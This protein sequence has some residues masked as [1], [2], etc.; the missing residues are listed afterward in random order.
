MKNNESAG[1]NLT[2]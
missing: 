1:D 2:N